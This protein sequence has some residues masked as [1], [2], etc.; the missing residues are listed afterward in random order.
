MGM[1]LPLQGA[2]D[3]LGRFTQ[4]AVLPL[5]SRTLPWADS[6]C[7]FGAWHGEHSLECNRLRFR[8]KLTPT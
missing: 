2:H 3:T 8:R 4:G 1:Q 6:S 5:R 7:P